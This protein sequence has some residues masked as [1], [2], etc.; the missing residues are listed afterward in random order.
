MSSLN[1]ECDYCG[2]SFKNSKGLD[3]H[4][5]KKKPCI[6]KDKMD[7]NKRNKRKSDLYDKLLKEGKIKKSP[8]K[9]VMLKIKKSPKKKKQSKINIIKKSYKTLKK[10]YDTRLNKDKSTFTSSN[11][12]PTPIGCIEEMLSKIPKD[13]WKKKGLRI[14]DPCCGNGNFHLVTYNLLKEHHSNNDILEKMLYFNDTNEKRISKIKSMFCANKFKLKI[15]KADFLEYPIDIEEENKYDIIMA[16]PPFAKLLPNGKRA[17]KNHNLIKLFLKKSIDLLKKDGFLVYITPNNWMSLADRNKLIKEMTKLKFHYLNI[18]TAKKWFPKIGSSFTWYVL[19]NVEY[20]KDHTFLVE[21]CYKKNSYTTEVRSQNRDYIP[22]FYNNLIQNIL[23]KVIDTEKYDKF[24]VET[25]SDLHKY[26]KR[27]LI[28]KDK[29]VEFKHRLIHTPKQTVYAKRA[30][31][32][33]EGYKVFISTTDKYSTFVDNC[34]MTQSIAFI[35]CENKE[36]AEKYKK[37]LDHDL[38]KFINNIC[39][40]GNFNNIRILQRF[41]IPVNMNLDS[42]YDD[43]DITEEEREFISLNL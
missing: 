17:S 24:K 11:D 22:L 39:R 25:T 7:E 13:I 18:H 43:F 14:L 2:Y 41:P 31:K 33:Q 37:I 4:K 10:Y 29:T 34:G 32:F 23:D 35:R 16:N 38:Y 9:K 20:E 19:Q 40:W 42:V 15:S 1:Y 30:H 3:K 21:G 28:S 8:P 36:I 26:T 27:D 6:T 12:E 5:N